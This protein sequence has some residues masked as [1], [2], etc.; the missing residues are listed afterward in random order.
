MS[1][2]YARPAPP[3]T[4]IYTHIYQSITLQDLTDRS[5]QMKLERVSKTRQLTPPQ[6]Q[7]QSIAIVIF[8]MSYPTIDRVHM[9]KQ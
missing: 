7:L 8:T 2:A 3:S 4:I 6:N 5:L 9:Q 1:K